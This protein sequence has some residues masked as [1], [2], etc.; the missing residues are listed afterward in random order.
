[1]LLPRVYFEDQKFSTALTYFAKLPTMTL[2][3]FTLLTTVLIYSP[4]CLG[5]DHDL[6]EVNTLNVE[7]HIEEIVRHGPHPAG[8]DAQRQV[9]QYIKQQLQ[10][11]GLEVRSQ[12]FHAI[13]PIGRVKMNN[14]WGVLK[15]E[16]EKVIILASHYDSKYFEDFNFLGANDSGSSSAL[17]LELSR[18]LSQHNPIPYSI[19]FSFFDGEEAFV[20]WTDLD[21]LYGSREFV[22]MLQANSQINSISALI[23]LDM[24]GGKNLTLYQDTNSSNWLNTIIWNEATRMGYEYIFRKR[25]RT[26]VQ[27]DHVPFAEIGISVID[28]IDLNYPHWHQND[29]V[30]KLSPK[31]IAI[32]GNVVLSSLQ[33]I[34]IHL[35]K[36]H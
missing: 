28:I 1:M 35:S 23:L 16:K 11:Y 6:E 20:E 30:D 15:G 8:S 9:G 36:I 27:D 19:W 3:S 31:N 22:K 14:V 4:S 25:G 21:S 17:L 32:V 33:K 24:I 5:S 10:S 34:A 2:F 26:S 7:N 18:I 29:T 13:T 12:T